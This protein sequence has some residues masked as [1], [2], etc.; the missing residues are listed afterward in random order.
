MTEAETKEIIRLLLVRKKEV[1]N[2]IT[3]LTDVIE[4]YSP[5]INKKKFE[6]IFDNGKFA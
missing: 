2:Q 6:W 1:E 5:T 3:V 4:M